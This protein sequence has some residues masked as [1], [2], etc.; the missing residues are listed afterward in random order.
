MISLIIMNHQKCIQKVLREITTFSI[1]LM[2]S[3][4]LLHMSCSNQLATAMSHAG[5]L[6]RNHV[7]YLGDLLRGGWL[8]PYQRL[9]DPCRIVPHPTYLYAL[10]SRPHQ[11]DV[12]KNVNGGI[13]LELEDQNNLKPPSSTP[14]VVFVVFGYGWMAWTDRRKS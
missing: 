4:L 14:T 6:P 11:I 12:G 2:L 7:G 5:P 10:T 1:E 8:F 3:Q 13:Q 9:R